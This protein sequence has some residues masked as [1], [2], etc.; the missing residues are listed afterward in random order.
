MAR[1]DDLFEMLLLDIVDVVN[2]IGEVYEEVAHCIETCK[3]DVKKHYDK[4]SID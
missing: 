1:I 3:K 2:P 4:K